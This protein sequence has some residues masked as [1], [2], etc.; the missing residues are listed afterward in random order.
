M[1]L[2][3]GILLLIICIGVYLIDECIELIRNIIGKEEISREQIRCAIIL[4]FTVSYL[5]YLF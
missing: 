3:F 4:I 5:V 1:W 2:F